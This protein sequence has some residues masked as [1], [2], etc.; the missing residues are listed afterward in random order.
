KAIEARE[1]NGQ[2]YF[3]RV[4]AKAAPFYALIGPLLVVASDEGLLREALARRSPDAKANSSLTQQMRQLLGTEQHLAR[5]WL[6]PRAFDGAIAAKTVEGGDEQRAVLKNVLTYWKALDGV[7]V[8]VVLQHDATL[9]FAV[10][11][12]ID[13]LSPKAGRLL[14]EAGKPSDLWQCFP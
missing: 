5:L 14:A 6:N 7:A 4:D 9:T 12:R 3:Q 2:S 1:H 8:G 11:A 13:G 10:R